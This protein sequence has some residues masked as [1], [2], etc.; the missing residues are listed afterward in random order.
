MMWDEDKDSE[1]VLAISSPERKIIVLDY[2]INKLN[3]LEDNVAKNF[4][5]ET[6]GP[7]NI[8]VF[9]TDKDKKNEL[10]IYTK[11]KTQVEEFIIAKIRLI[12]KN[13]TLFKLSKLGL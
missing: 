5:T 7:I 13:I 3:S 11:T 4:I 10:L 12:L 9:D 1:I 8:D 6:Y 2:N